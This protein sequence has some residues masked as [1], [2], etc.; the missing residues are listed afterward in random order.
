VDRKGH[1]SIE[2][3]RKGRKLAARGQD[4]LF[5]CNRF[6]RHVARPRERGKKRE[7]NRS[8]RKKLLF[9][10]SERAGVYI[11]TDREGVPSRECDFDRKS[12]KGG[13]AMWTTRSGVLRQQ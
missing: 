4:N 7:E 9:A 3:Q 12:R 1:I 2:N 6:P 8:R 11:L 13:K 5:R 10:R